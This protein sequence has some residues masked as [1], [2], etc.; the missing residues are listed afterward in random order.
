MGG[1]HIAEVGRRMTE[2]WGRNGRHSNSSRLK[3]GTIGATDKVIDVASKEVG[4]HM[5]HGNF[6]QGAIR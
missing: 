6:V 1:S 4:W 2:L 3:E 5:P